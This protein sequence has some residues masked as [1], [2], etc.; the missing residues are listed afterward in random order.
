MAS[1]EIPKE[2]PI[3]VPDA[4]APAAETV[5]DSEELKAKALKQG[6][7]QLSMAFLLPGSA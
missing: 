5:A 3:V 4:A 6:K 2:V 7:F 1:V